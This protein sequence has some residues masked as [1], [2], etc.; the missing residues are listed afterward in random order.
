MA[1]YTALAP[2]F[3]DIAN[4]IRSKTGETGQITANTFPDKIANLS[5]LDQINNGQIKNVLCDSNIKKNNFVFAKMYEDEP[6]PCIEGL[7]SSVYFSRQSYWNCPFFVNENTV[8]NF[9]K[10]SYSNGTIFIS[11]N[12]ITRNSK[13]VPTSIS[14]TDLNSFNINGEMPYIK[15]VNSQTFV[16]CSYSMTASK[17]MIRVVKFNNNWTNYEL[18]QNETSL[19]FDRT[20]SA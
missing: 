15:K 11:V 12:T 4:A 6:Y 2:L 5:S 14:S 3:T 8:I 13:G 10:E 19:S 17:A 7:N 16:I 20:D 1:E 18:I 9:S